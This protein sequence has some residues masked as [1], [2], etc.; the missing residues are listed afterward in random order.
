[1]DG[2]KA[3]LKRKEKIVGVKIRRQLKMDKIFKIF[4]EW[5]WR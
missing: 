5:R 4:E 2:T 1:M 3:R